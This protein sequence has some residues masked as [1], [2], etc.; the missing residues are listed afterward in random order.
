[1]VRNAYRRMREF[2]EARTAGALDDQAF[3]ADGDDLE[4]AGMSLLLQVFATICALA[5]VVQGLV[6]L[7]AAFESGRRFSRHVGTGRLDFDD[8][9]F[10]VVFIS[11]A[12]AF[13]SVLFCLRAL[14]LRVVRPVQSSTDDF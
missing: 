10:F 9:L 2:P 1:M 5:A 3:G 8:L 11:A 12:T 7:V 14:R 13:G 6:Y 4:V